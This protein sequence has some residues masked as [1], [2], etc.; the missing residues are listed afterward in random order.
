MVVINQA[1]AQSPQWQWSKNSGGSSRDYTGG[2]A[3]DVS[4][5]IYVAGSF[6]S[7]SI[8]FGTITLT[9]ADNTGNTQDIF[10]V[11][12]DSSGNVIWA[13]NA[14]GPTNDDSGASIVTD[15]IGNIYL[16]GSFYSPSINFGTNTLTNTDNTGNTR[17]IFI[18]KYDSSGNVI[19]A[20]NAGGQKNEG[21]AG[22][23][24]DASG[25][26]YMTGT[27]YSPSINFGT[28]TLTNTDST[29]NTCDIYIMKYDSSGNV[30]W[31]KSAGVP[32]WDYVES[33]AKDFSGNVYITG[34]F[35]NT[36][37]TFGTITLTNAGSKDIFIVKYDGSGNVTW[38]KR[39][40]GTAWDEGN[41]IF[42]DTTGN[43]LL[44]G[45]FESSTI[46]FG[47]TI[48]SN[49]GSSDIF[50]AK[51]DTSGNVLWAI[52]AGGTLADEGKKIITDATGN[53]YIIGDFASSSLNIGTT[54][55][56]NEGLSDIFIMK[57]DD[58]GNPLWAKSVG[59]SSIDWGK[60]IATDAIGNTYIIGEYYYSSIVFGTDT[61]TNAGYSD[62]FLAKLNAGVTNIEEIS[63]T[64]DCTIFPNP[65][66]TQVTLRT[67]V[68]LKNATLQVINCLGQTIKEI[69]NIS[70]QT[71]SLM[72]DN[73]ETGIYF[74]RLTQGNKVITIKKIVIA[75]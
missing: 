49:Q 7:T 12:Y 21:G 15:P 75:D 11:K 60:G 59:G 55:L 65:F 72:R 63:F 38:A 42:I 14:G 47:T 70:G 34:E 29:G 67:K 37:I 4:G 52:R 25:N 39:A 9:N 48:L 8:N 74:L 16:A 62:I 26:V 19:W 50:I 30:L 2:I 22:I 58:T 36:P 3:T 53:V 6:Y 18:V 68:Q 73:L 69:E 45:Y 41:G 23:V 46:S 10:I 13:K 35:G 71:T 32:G 61:L 44:T 43:I 20:K 27:F 51:Y 54:T 31:A 40:G 57:Y 17:D 5:N 66:S 1:I 64:D 28:N 33:I 56:T 24:T